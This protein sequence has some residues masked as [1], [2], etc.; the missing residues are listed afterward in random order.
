MTITELQ[1]AIETTQRQIDW[2]WDGETIDVLQAR[3]FRY[4]RELADLILTETNKYTTL[5]ISG[6]KPG[7]GPLRFGG[8]NVN[9]VEISEALTIDARETVIDLTKLPLGTKYIRMWN[10]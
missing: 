1:Q 4:E 10:A 9:G 7:T 2:E 5:K 8:E 6:F 3:K